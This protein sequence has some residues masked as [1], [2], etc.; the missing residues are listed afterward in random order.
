MK[1]SLVWLGLIT[2]GIV[3][4][5]VGYK[6]FETYERFTNPDVKEGFTSGET[7]LQITT[8]PADSK[9]FIDNNGRTVCCQGSV[10]NGKCIGNLIC[11]LSEGG[12]NIPTCNTWYAAL[13]DERGRDRCPTTMPTY[14]EGGKLGRGCTVGKRNKDGTGPDLS[15][16]KFCKLYT[17][18]KDELLKEDSCTNQKM[19]DE[20]QCPVPG[21]R[22]MF[23]KWN[24]NIPPNVHCEFVNPTNGL[25]IN[26][27]EDIS[28]Y[29]Q[30]EYAKKVGILPNNWE[31]TYSSSNK[32]NWCR[33]RKMVDMDKTVS[34][35]D[36]KYVSVNPNSGQ[37]SI[38]NFQLDKANKSRIQSKATKLCWDVYE[39]K[40]QNVTPVQTWD[41]LN[42]S[43]QQFTFD[44][45]Q[46]LTIGHSGKCVDLSY[47]KDIVQ[48]DCHNGANQKWYSDAQGRIRSSASDK[49][50]TAPREKGIGM[51]VQPCTSSENQKFQIA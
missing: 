50:I 43:N 35:E 23:S 1:V 8:C 41:C 45:K 22:K 47:G 42:N 15:S 26:C 32:I 46:R 12:K 9:S 27:A 7:E 39:G 13:L 38:P 29:A 11:T 40:T 14:F 21:A 20:A 6:G 4:I 19:I 17:T 51:T 34:F 24:L 25:P 44:S 10:E 18:E 30:H 33:I 5:L 48:Y 2:I 16:A 36:L 31:D 28:T 49:C 37:P 3:L